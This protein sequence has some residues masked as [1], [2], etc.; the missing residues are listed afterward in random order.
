MAKLAEETESKFVSFKGKVEKDTTSMTEKA[1][2]NTEKL[3]NTTA[4]DFK[5]MAVWTDKRFSAHE[6]WL[7]SHLSFCVW[8]F[9]HLGEGPITY[10]RAEREGGFIRNSSSIRK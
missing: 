3:M 5:T 2:S 8:N 10:N 7:K 6:K 9:G 4:D 1:K